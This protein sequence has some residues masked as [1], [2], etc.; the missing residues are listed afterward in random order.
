M[1]PDHKLR[2]YE[3]VRKIVR[4]SSSNG[5]CNF[6]HRRSNRFSIRSNPTHQHLVSSLSSTGRMRS[7][8]LC[9]II[10]CSQSR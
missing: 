4:S 2:E 10:D 5:Y 6:K 9:S 1:V 8:I 7:I 3:R